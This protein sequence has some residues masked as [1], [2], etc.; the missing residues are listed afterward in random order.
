MTL[1]ACARVGRMSVYHGQTIRIHLPSYIAGDAVV[2]AF[3]WESV[4]RLVHTL[5]DGYSEEW[6]GSNWRGVLT[7]DA[8]DDLHDLVG[9]LNDWET[10]VDDDFLDVRSAYDWLAQ[11]TN[12]ELGIRSDMTE[13]DVQ[14]LKDKLFAEAMAEGIDIVEGLEEGILR[15][16]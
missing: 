5:F 2:D 12:E 16:R 6:D 4:R 11:W 7:D 9:I 14:D 15:R 10:W 1:R 13:D 3:S 8:V